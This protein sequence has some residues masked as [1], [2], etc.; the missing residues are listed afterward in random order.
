MKKVVCAAVCV[1]LLSIHVQAQN[2]YVYLNNQAG[3]NQ[4][5]AWQIESDGSLTQLT[6]SPF[7]TGGQG[8]SGPVESMAVVRTEVGPILYAA[9]GGDTSVSG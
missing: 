7:N 4:I 5:T 3:P 1:L 8:Q 9:N 2:R 6:N